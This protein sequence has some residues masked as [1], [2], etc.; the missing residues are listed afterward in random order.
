METE[1]TET[2]EGEGIGKIA[3]EQSTTTTMIIDDEDQK[4]S[5][6]QTGNQEMNIEEDW[7]GSKTSS[8][9]LRMTNFEAQSE[10]ARQL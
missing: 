10:E 9:Q 7:H 4:N 8:T 6:E 3:A 2:I 5:I 1:R